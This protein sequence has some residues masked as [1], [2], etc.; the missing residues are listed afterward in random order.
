[1][2]TG[3]GSRSAI[4]TA[5]THIIIA[6]CVVGSGCDDGLTTWSAEAQ[7]PDGIWRAAASSRSEGGGPTAYDFTT[8]DLKWLRGSHPSTR[9]LGFTHQF[10]TMNLK[11]E[12]IT[13]RH[14]N[15]TYRPSARHGDHASLDFQVVKMSGIEISLRDLSRETSNNWQ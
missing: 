10:P 15:V 11:M 2:K 4:P 1:M 13:P 9:V 12:W 14:L 7:S 6:V 5:I 8:V 3:A